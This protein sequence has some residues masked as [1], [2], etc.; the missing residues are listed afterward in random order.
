MRLWFYDWFIKPVVVVDAATQRQL[1]I[2]TSIL[3]TLL[4]A[5]TL[6]PVPISLFNSIDSG[7]GYVI[8]VGVCSICLCYVLARFGA[9]L[10]A[11]W[12]M[13]CIVSV[14]IFALS[15]ADQNPLR[16]YGLIYLVIPIF[17]SWILFS[18]TT[19]VIMTTVFIMMMSVMPLVFEHLDFTEIL[20]GPVTI[21][22][23]TSFLLIAI[24]FI[25]DF[26]GELFGDAY[27]ATDEFSLRRITSRLPSLYMLLDGDRVSYINPA[28]LNLLG[29]EKIDQVINNT[30]T[31]F[32]PRRMQGDSNIRVVC[33]S[34]DETFAVKTKQSVVPLSGESTQLDIV[35]QPLSL[36]V[37]SPV[38]LSIETFPETVVETGSLA[39]LERFAQS[40]DDYVLVHDS[41]GKILHMNASARELTGLGDDQL[42]FINDVLPELSQFDDHSTGKKDIRVTEWLTADSEKRQVE[43]RA[44]LADSDGIQMVIASPFNDGVVML[45]KPHGGMVNFFES[46]AIALAL[47]TRKRRRIFRVN[48]N[49]CN[50]TG[51]ERD[52]LLGQSL[53]DL[54]LWDNDRFSSM[55]DHLDG[56]DSVKELEFEL[57]T[58]DGDHLNVMLSMETIEIMGVSS[59]MLIIQDVTA[60]SLTMSILAERESR[61]R[62]V[63]ELMSDYAYGWKVHDGNLQLEWIT[64]AFERITGYTVDEALGWDEWILLHPD[65]KPDQNRVR[66]AIFKGNSETLDYRLLTK[67]GKLRW[68]RDYSRPIWD[69]ERKNVIGIYGAVQDISGQ[70]EAENAL[71]IHAL[72]QAIVAEIGQK[73][74]AKA[75]TYDV[76]LG[77]A[78]PLIIQVLDIQYCVALEL[79]E[80]GDYLIPRAS[81]GWQ[82]QLKENIPLRADLVSQ[83]GYTLL[84]KEPVFVEDM[85]V[86]K[87]FSP[88]PLLEN[89]NV[90]S[91]LTVL[92]HWQTNVIGMLGVFST[93]QHR[94]T[95]DD[96]NFL[97]SIANTLSAFIEQHRIAEAETQ[98]RILAEALRDTAA[99]LNSTLD[100]EDVIERVLSH[101]AQVVPHDAASIMLIDSQ[102]ARIIKYRGFGEFAY[103]TS[104]D[105]SSLSELTTNDLPIV[106]YMI[107]NRQPV[108]ISRVRGDPR[109]RYL[110]TETS[111]IESYVGAPIFFQGDLIGIL[112]V[113]SSIP[114]HFVDDD[115][116]RLMTFANQASIALHN[117]RYAAELQ[118][119]VE[120][121]T[122][123]LNLEHRRLQAILD[124]TAEGIFYTQ[125]L[126]IRYV[127]Q[128]LCQLVGYS[129]EEFIGKD[130][131]FLVGQS[132]S[133]ELHSTWQD[134]RHQLLQGQVIRNE[135]R[136]RRKDGS[137]FD[138]ALTLSMAGEISSLDDPITTVTLVRDISQQKALDKQR[139]RFI[140]SASH[141]LRSPIT[142]INTRLY[143]MRHKPDDMEHHITLLERVVERMN[144]LVEDLLDRIRIEQGIIQL[145]RRNFVLQNLVEKIV[146]IMRDDAALKQLR[147]DTDY[148][149]QPM[150]VFADPDRLY[151]VITNLIGNAINYTP[152]GGAV[153]VVV[154]KHEDEDGQLFAVIQVVDT[155]VG[156]SAEDLPHIFDAFYRAN[157]HVKGTGL[158]LNIARELIRMH[159][160]DVRV[161]SR[162]GEGS[163]FSILLPYTDDGTIF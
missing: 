95:L 8:V 144:I 137:I 54:N 133:D 110:Y 153:S 93:T 49:F 74:L 141:E 41:D 72:E 120:E 128:T 33:G 139:D 143:L 25:V 59:I 163:T 101:V 5:V 75:T 135:V 14:L 90:V 136:I 91:G 42:V 148:I 111:W 81:M 96:I 57:R 7:T 109:W 32:M 2:L 156:I 70:Y 116:Q 17:L 69:A 87:R 44:R 104:D 65:D 123:Q 138:A 51:Y 23:A 6:I 85:R 140:S 47:I 77:E 37:D 73:A 15:V 99:A 21:V 105:E 146:E 103:T 79:N 19:M 11:A 102:R 46:N 9:Y 78:L 145:R 86:E 63:S 61:Y 151:Q 124:A 43:V 122:T 97:Q 132:L 127:N 161:D 1:N 66:R 16:I 106:E 29:S 100:L 88:D 64:G 82:G 129:T 10:G 12:G 155:G 160:G 52:T 92:I 89:V 58:C 53:Q 119:R 118:Q 112:N 20:L 158:G 149:D 130:A 121:R 45:R 24:S 4:V 107:A 3:V 98:Q 28:G 40:T 114:G 125:D 38:Q 131:S 134:V 36:R 83:F 48:Q 115:A 35:M 80:D 22:G 31:E 142:S 60:E 147:M 18:R 162:P 39:F 68:V 27:S 30:M 126:E 154:T 113:D 76:L 71:R 152:E 67:S 55:L 34:A 13:F 84:V 157:Q 108:A 50:L 94:F 159:D 150:R 62:T 117:A 56:Y 26:R